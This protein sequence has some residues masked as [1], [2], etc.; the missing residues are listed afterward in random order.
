LKS[1][2]PHQANYHQVCLVQLLYGFTHN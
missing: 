1:Y 2:I